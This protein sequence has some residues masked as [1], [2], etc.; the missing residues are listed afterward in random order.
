[1]TVRGTPAPAL[2]LPGTYWEER[3]QRFAGEGQG[4][5]AVCSYGMPEFYNRVIDWSQYLALRRWLAVPRGARVL[6]VG[7]GVGRW[8]RRLARRGA[9]VTGIDLSPTMIAEARRRAE[10]EGVATNCR[11][12]TQDLK[13]L[14]AGAQFDVVLGVTVLQHILDPRALRSAVTRMTDHLAPGG[15]MVLL[16]AAPTAVAKHCDS[17]IFRARRR[18]EYLELFTSC[19]LATRAITGVDPAPFKYRL[20]PH[21]RRLPMALRIA[22]TNAASALSLPI[23]AMLGRHAVNRS[24]H[25]V[26]VLQRS[27][28]A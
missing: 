9:E 26:F 20:L 10:A 4:L 6:D 21:L 8:S 7:C 15:Q 2:Y 3:A 22:A 17:S 11:F 28:N 18:D 13:D 27:T 12:M 19:G 16:E 5:A 14:D 1:M 24:W 25:A 23:D